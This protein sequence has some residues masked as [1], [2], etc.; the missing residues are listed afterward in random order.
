MARVETRLSFL[1]QL[2]SFITWGIYTPMSIEVTCASGSNMDDDGARV[3]DS[4]EG[5][6]A[7]LDAGEPFYLPLQ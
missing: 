5:A 7:A 3:V 6:E 4:P 2:A 1:N